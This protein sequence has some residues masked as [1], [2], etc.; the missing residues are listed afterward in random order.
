MLPTSLAVEVTNH[1]Y[2]SE[3]N[4]VFATSGSYKLTAMEVREFVPLAPLTTFGIGGPA[5]WYAEATTE[6]EIVQAVQLAHEREI[7]LFI[8]GGGSNLLVSDAGFPGLV[9]RI[10]LKGIH[11]E[12]KEDKIIFS[13]AAG[14]EWESLVN[15]ALERNCSG[16]ECLAGIPGTVGGTPI[17]NV[18]AYGQE[19][20]ETI[21]GVRAFDRT[22]NSFVEL[23]REDCRFSYR[24]SVFNT[25]ARNRYIVSRVDYALTPGGKPKI[26]YADL[27]RKFGEG[28]IPSLPEVASV[29]REVRKSKG[30]LMVEGDIDCQSA[31]SFFKNPIIGKEQLLHLQA[32]EG[33]EIPH[34]VVDDAHVKV[35]AAWLMERSGFVKG[36]SVGQAGISSRHTLAL[37]NRG[38]AKAADILALRDDVVIQ[39]QLR[40]GI[41][42]R[43]EPVY[44]K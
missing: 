28:H 11:C 19:A 41:T 27:R 6:E 23:S 2:S 30:M 26:E 8:L 42:L 40:F 14:E 1:S 29:V 31:G 7:P 24:A 20:G 17:Q 13:A 22:T 5:H 32:R 33:V 10:C 12:P 34:Y 43:A 25:V 36:Y 38:G 37:I 3:G 4:H 16:V 35:P 39:V 9:L 44:V 18:G 21:I 15:L